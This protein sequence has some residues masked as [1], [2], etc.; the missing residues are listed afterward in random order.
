MIIVDINQIMISNLMVQ[1]NGRNAVEL[2][3]DLV[4]HMVL[5]SLRAHN[6]KFRK[7]YGQMIIACDSSN[8]WRRTAFPNYKAGRKEN[9]AKSEHDWEF[10]FDVLAKIKKEIKDFLPYKVVA[11]ES[12]EADDIIATLCKRTNEKVLILSGDK[13]FIQLHNDRIKQYNPVLNKFVGKDENPV[14][15]IREHILKGDRSD[16][17]PNVLSDDNVFIEGRRQTPL[18]R[19]KIE[20]WVNEVVPTFNEEQ[21]KNYER[22]RQLIDL[23]YI[24]KEIEDNINREF[25]NVEVATRD[26]ILGYFINKKLKTLIESIDEF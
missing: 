22:N 5:N 12:T 2:S 13:D 8:V 1:I 16:G 18:S 10:I 9:R 14:I 3:E 21:Q 17:I 15:Y 25:D 6:K 26:K 4:R 19:K 7:E 11:V 20:A 24:P 23:N